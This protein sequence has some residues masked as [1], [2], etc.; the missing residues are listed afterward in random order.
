MIELGG[1]ERPQDSDVDKLADSPADTSVE[2]RLSFAREV[3]A[4][5]QDL[6]RTMDQKANNLLSSVALLTAAL[7]ILASNAITAS[8]Q[9][10][11]QRL[12]KG[13]GVLL[14]AVYLLMAFNVIYIATRVYQARTHSV[15]PDT[16]APGMLFP[17]MLL[18]RYAVEGKADE[19]AYLER[20]QRI[21]PKEILHDYANQIIEVSDIY[22]EKQKLVNLALDHFRRLSILWVVTMLVLMLIV[23]WLR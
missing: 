1:Q 12:F 15:R 10:D 11:W 14:I 6:T 9:E 5:V 18:E 23:V 3:F 19:D 22:R 21:G 20:L 7:G 4:N 8:T 13:A 17:L 16:A 2:A